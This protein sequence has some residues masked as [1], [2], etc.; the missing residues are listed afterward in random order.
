[1]TKEESMEVIN[2]ASSTIKTL[3]WQPISAVVVSIFDSFYYNRSTH[4]I[5]NLCEEIKAR[6][7]NSEVDCTDDGDII[8]G[9][10][11]SLY[12]NYGTSPRSGWIKENKEDIIYCI[13]E[14][15]EDCRSEGEEK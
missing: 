1:M 4:H 6:L 8:Y 5:L 7:N 15:I 11:V 9:F 13:N 14:I 3:N 10:L 12:G 2:I